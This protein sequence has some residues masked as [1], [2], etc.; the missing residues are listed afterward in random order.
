LWWNPKIT[1]TLQGEIKM[2]DKQRNTEKEFSSC[3]E[4]MPFAN[5]MQK[6]MN[7]RGECHDFDC[8]EMMRKMMDKEEGCHDFDCAEMMRKM[9]TMGCWPLDDSDES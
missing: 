6:I 2:T 5:M 8:A 7:Q 1:D 4:G 3:C 9:M